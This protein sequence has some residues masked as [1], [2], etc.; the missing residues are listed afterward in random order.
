MPHTSVIRRRHSESRGRKA[1]RAKGNRITAILEAL[2]RE[3][4][5]GR[6]HYIFG[7]LNAYHLKVATSLESRRNVAELCPSRAAGAIHDLLPD[8]TVILALCEGRPVGSVAVYLDGPLGLPLDGTCRRLLDPLRCAGRSQGQIGRLAVARDLPLETAR[9]VMLHLF[10]AAYVAARV[11]EGV[12]DVVAAVEPRHARFAERFFFRPMTELWG[13]KLPL[14]LDFGE[15]E[16][17]FL[18][19]YAGRAGDRDLDLFLRRDQEW[20]ADWLRAKRRPLGE[21]ALLTLLSERRGAFSAL[22]VE[23]RHA[24]EDLYLAYDLNEVLS[25]D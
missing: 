10:K 23:A 12:D 20:L 5:A 2:E 7:P 4:A 16:M 8:T 17:A 24:F 1:L 13:G 6:E 3:V 15:S 9:S 14:R 21:E 19:M 22:S 18:G 25:T 11:V